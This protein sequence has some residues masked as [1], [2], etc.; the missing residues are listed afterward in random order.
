MGHVVLD[1]SAVP[2]SPVCAS[3]CPEP[4]TAVV[5]P[6]LEHFPSSSHSSFTKCGR[7][8]RWLHCTDKETE[9][10]ILGLAGIGVGVRTRIGACSS[11]LM[12]GEG[13][14]G[15]SGRGW[16]GEGVMMYVLASQHAGL[17]DVKLTIQSKHP[18]LLVHSWCRVV[19]T[20]GSFR[21]SS[22]DS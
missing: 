19:V 12:W 8:F 4:H 11:K 7:D 15:A 5:S 1:R 18:R 14:G 3:V 16:R 2:G 20:S 9:G 21:S 22:P 6:G 10:E 17:C 13:M